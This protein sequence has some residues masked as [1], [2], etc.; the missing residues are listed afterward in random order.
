MRVTR[1][2]K[3]SL[4]DSS[5]IT[6]KTSPTSPL[7]LLLCSEHKIMQNHTPPPTPQ[8]TANCTTSEYPYPNLTLTCGSHCK[9]G[10][11]TYDTAK[12]TI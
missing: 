2:K 4:S 10:L 5:A 11:N 9:V 3:L 7:F 6:E 1:V 12:T 8:V